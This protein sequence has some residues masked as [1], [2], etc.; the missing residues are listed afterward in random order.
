[1]KCKKR[2][3]KERPRNRKVR[4]Q[5]ADLCKSGHCEPCMNEIPKMAARRVEAGRLVGRSLKGVRRCQNNDDRA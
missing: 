1:M 3:L 4:I 2:P 5:N